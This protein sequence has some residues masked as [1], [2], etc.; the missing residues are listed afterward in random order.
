MQEAAR[1]AFVDEAV[2]ATRARNGILLYVSE[3]EHDCQVVPDL[4]IRG[5]V[6]G[7]PL[8]V[9]AAQ[10][11]RAGTTPAASL[12]AIEAIGVL[13]EEPFPADDSDNPD[14]ISNRPRMR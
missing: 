11:V 9:I 3:F 2:H 6:E 13:L 7:G 14:E 8:N 12:E 4:G 10:V 5:K 1:L